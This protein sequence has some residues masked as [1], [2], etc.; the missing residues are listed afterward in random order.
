MPEQRQQ[1][2]EEASCKGTLHASHDLQ[3]VH[4]KLD[5]EGHKSR[6]TESITSPQSGML[7]QV[8]KVFFTFARVMAGRFQNSQMLCWMYCL[9]G[10][11]RADSALQT[12]LSP[13]HA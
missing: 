8:L 5:I 1:R 10:R 6:P 11:S 13:P 7:A 9:P 4:G 2:G 3:S 12:P